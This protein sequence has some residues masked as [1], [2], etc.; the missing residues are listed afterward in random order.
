MFA[1]RRVNKAGPS[2][3]RCRRNGTQATSS[4]EAVEA[5]VTPAAQTPPVEATPKP[6]PPKPKETNESTEPSKP[7]GP[8]RFWPTTRPSISLER[9]RQYSRPI[10]V[11]VLPAYDHALA[12]IKRDSELQKEELKEYQ[13]EL[14][15]EE[16]GARNPGHLERLREKVRI[17]EV[18]SEINLPSVRWKARN[19]LADMSKTVYRHLLEQRW[20]EEGE[21][22]L[23]MERI[24]QMNV[25]PDMMGSLHP[26]FDLRVNFPEPLPEDVRLR[27]RV[28]RKYQKVEPGVYLSPEQTRKPPMMYTTVFHTEPRFYTLLMLDLDVPNPETQSFQS[29]LHWLQP[30][31]SLSSST[32]SV[33]LPTTHTKYIP[34]HPQKGTPYHRYVLLFAPQTGSE[35]IKVPQFSDSDRLGFDYRQFAEQYGLDASKGGAAHMWRGVWDESVSKIYKDVLQIEEPVFARQPKEDPYKA[36]K[37]EKKYL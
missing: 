36:M 3:L 27:T 1:L 22:D 9:P 34:P 8:Y 15:I 28:R 18:Q 30:N 14:E 4:I 11:G 13:A 29:Y 31:I 12:Y 2:A 16:K 5:S 37:Q 10:G 6:A 25:V 24:H 19:G 17:L 21:L 7:K 35:A 32:T 26:S 23:L 33:D 20:R